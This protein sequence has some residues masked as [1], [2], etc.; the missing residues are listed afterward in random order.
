[1]RRIDE[2]AT[3]IA[4]FSPKKTERKKKKPSM[5]NIF[6][7]EEMARLKKKKP[8]MDHKERFKTA[9]G[10]WKTSKQNPKNK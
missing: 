3:V 8:D 2:L 4:G 7:K 5:Y 6:M 10:N 1:M 9:A